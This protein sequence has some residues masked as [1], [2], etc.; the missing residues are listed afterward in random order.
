MSRT[1]C[2]STPTISPTT[3]RQV[4]SYGT[5]CKYVQVIIKPQCLGDHPQ[6]RHT[7][8]HNPKPELTLDV[9][10]ISQLLVESLARDSSTASSIAGKEPQPVKKNSSG[11]G[12]TCVGDLKHLRFMML[13]TTQE[14]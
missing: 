4:Y 11:V 3:G 2:R 12:M 8:T 7:T 13:E 5:A 9:R 1:S 6:W 10:A 14:G